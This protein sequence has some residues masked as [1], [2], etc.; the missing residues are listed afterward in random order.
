MSTTNLTTV[1]PRGLE[2]VWL[3]L[4]L[5]WTAANTWGFAWSPDG[6]SW[7]DYNFSTFAATM[8]PTHFGP[9]VSSWGQTVPLVASFE[10]VRVTE[11][12]L[13]V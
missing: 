4:R 12:D 9:W 3:Y 6:V 2:L 7:T 10:Y 1:I 11:S 5:V 8:T 13:S